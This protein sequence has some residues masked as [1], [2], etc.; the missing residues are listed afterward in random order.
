MNIEYIGLNIS[1][2][3]QLTE[4]KTYYHWDSS[5]ESKIANP[6][7]RVLRP[8]DYAVR[9]GIGS[10]SFSG[11]FSNKSFEDIIRFVE[12]FSLTSYSIIKQQFFSI[13]ESGKDY[14]DPI[15]SLKY[16][17]GM[18]AKCS[19]Y[20]GPLKDKNNMRCYLRKVLQVFDFS[21]YQGLVHFFVNSID[22]R[23]CDIFLVGWDV[24]R[25]ALSNGIYKIYLKIKNEKT[26]R[27]S[28][29]K[30]IPELKNWLFMKE[31]RFNVI[32][33]VFKGNLL[34][35]YNLYFKPY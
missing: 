4:T 17:N 21:L 16:A 29:I 5:L 19:I 31:L 11:F 26:A 15:L 12:N 7:P 30:I 14:Y 33:F 25:N 1:I 8:F 13:V 9:S 24:S 23:V 35:H 32:A 22:T 10:Y 6:L 34:V 3:G 20:V 18:L 2:D 27:E 28:I